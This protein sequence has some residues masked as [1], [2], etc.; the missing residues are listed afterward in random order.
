MRCEKQISVYMRT[1][2]AFRPIQNVMLI[3]PILAG[4]D[5]I[6]PNRIGSDPKESFLLDRCSFF[7]SSEKERERERRRK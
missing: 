4:L 6:E 1:I 5:R 3:A 7:L 2:T